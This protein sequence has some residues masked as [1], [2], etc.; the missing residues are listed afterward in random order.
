MS[1][2]LYTRFKRKNAAGISSSRVLIFSVPPNFSESISAHAAHVT[3]AA[4]AVAMAAASRGFVLFR[5]VGDEAFG[6]EQQ[7]CDAGRVLQGRARD[8]LRVNHAG[9]HEVFVFACSDVV[10]FVA[11]AFLDFLHD[12]RT[13]DTGIRRERTQRAFDGALD[14]VHADFFVVVV[15]LHGFNRRDAAD[16]CHAAAGN[17]SLFDGRAG[18]VQRVFHA[19]FLFLHFG[20]G[21]RA[22]VDD[23]HAARQ[24]RE[25]F[26]QFLAVVIARGFFD[27][28]ADLI[29][30]AL[31]L[32]RFASAFDDGRVFLVHDNALGA[33]QIFEAD[34]FKLDAEVF[35][36]ALAAGQHRD[37]FHH[38]FAAVAEAGGF[39]GA[40]VDRA[41]QFVHDESRERFALDF[42]RD[43]EQRFAGL[44]NLFEDRQQVL[45]VRDLLF[46]IQ[47]VSVFEFR[48]HRF[49]AGHEIR[50]GITLV[51]LHAF[52]HVERR[53]DGLRFFDR[54]RAVFADLVHRVGD[55]FANRGVPVGGNRRDLFD[56]LFVF[57]LFGNL[58][59]LFNRRRNGFV[60][61]ALDVDRAR[62]AGDVFQAFAINRLGQHR[63]R[64]RAVARCV[65][66]LA[67]DF[68]DHLRAH[69]F[70]RVFE[71][72]FL[73]DRHAVLGDRRGT[74]FFVNDHVAA[75]RAERCHDGA[76]EFLHA[77]EQR[78]PRLLVEYQLFG[79]HNILF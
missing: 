47:N 78:L 46:V 67:G 36:D 1:S 59:E 37:V 57:D 55:D 60:D 76:R 44:G 66:R 63:R 52:H 13:F 74:E 35:G 12:E 2:I 11:L 42:F 20:F 61:A 51:E 29:H 5:R 48:F 32:G 14:D 21:R 25:T 54:D 31:D 70:V 19:R 30:A 41:A 4:A 45:Q 65:A 17:N 39:D 68:A 56:F 43:D 33:A 73:R 62:A 34:A 79:C 18:R 49:G 8:F 72:D 3:H 69:V 64:R 9:F 23:G 10:T 50:R 58:R 15:A 27:L 26:L 40:D 38:G 16:Q 28:A 6:R 22:D 77:L 75:F 53:L 24:L 71:F 7:A